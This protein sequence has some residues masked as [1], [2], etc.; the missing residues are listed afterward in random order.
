MAKNSESKDKHLI[1]SL[2]KER[3]QLN[4]LLI[5][6]KNFSKIKLF[7]ISNEFNKEI[8]ELTEN[9][10]K[11]KR[12]ETDN[13]LMS[14]QRQ[15][16]IH[17]Q[18]VSLKKQ[19][20]KLDVEYNNLRMK[21]EKELKEKQIKEHELQQKMKNEKNLNSAKQSNV[22]KLVSIFCTCMLKLKM[23]EL[24]SNGE[25]FYSQLEELE[26]KD[27]E[28]RNLHM[29]TE[30]TSKIQS[31]NGNKIQREVSNLKKN[32]LQE[33]NLKLDAFQKVDELQSHLYDLEDEITNISQ[34]RPQS[35]KTK[36]NS[37]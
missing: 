34:V 21:F 7:T 5:K 2:Q 22:D 36:S 17:Q 8:T 33:R 37:K 31:I 11:I 12:R 15:L 26:D 10:D 32:L 1:E 4:S 18:K 25:I 19:L 30:K 23:N 3:S 16:L 28:L 6:Q 9:S 35:T 24:F 13:M 14:E 27:M 20:S 29:I